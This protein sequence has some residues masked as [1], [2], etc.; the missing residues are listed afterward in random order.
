MY[1][2]GSSDPKLPWNAERAKPTSRTLECA[3]G[4]HID[5]YHG[6]NRYTHH[7]DSYHGADCHTDHVDSYQSG[8][9]GEVGTESLTTKGDLW[10]TVVV[11][12][13][14]DCADSC[15]VRVS[16]GFGEQPVLD[17]V[18]AP[19]TRPG[20]AAWRTVQRARVVHHRKDLALA[21]VRQGVRHA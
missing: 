6:A 18:A 2:P 11:V 13:Y 4:A 1:F 15:A 8:Q 10:S 14:V 12:D 17:G 5:C 16:S 21:K 3:Q 19:D 7:V 9:G 20:N